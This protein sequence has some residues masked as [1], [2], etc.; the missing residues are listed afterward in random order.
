M[1]LNPTKIAVHYSVLK[2]YI[3]G[4]ITPEDRNAF[5]EMLL[6]QSQ[7]ELDLFRLI[8][9][10]EDAAIPRLTESKCAKLKDIQARMDIHP[11]WELTRSILPTNEPQGSFWAR[12]ITRLCPGISN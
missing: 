9:A 4:N 8:P 10:P 6:L 12:A 7:H 2:D 1:N 5:E 11:S 3:S